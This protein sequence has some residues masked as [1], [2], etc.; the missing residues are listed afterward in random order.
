MAQLRLLYVE[1]AMRGRGLG[2]ALV[3]AAVGFAREAGYATLTLW[4]NDVLSAAR[5]LYER[6]GFR[7]VASEPHARFGP[8]MV[9]ETWTLELRPAPQGDGVSRR[10]APGGRRRG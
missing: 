1:P 2:A 10:R 4:T 5:R 6:A 9:G 8:P 3:D 7:L